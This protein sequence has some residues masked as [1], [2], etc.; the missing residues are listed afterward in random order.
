MLPDVGGDLGVWARR[1]NRCAQVPV[2]PGRSQ[3]FIYTIHDLSG[4]MT[5]LVCGGHLVFAGTHPTVQHKDGAM[6]LGAVIII[7]IGVEFRVAKVVQVVRN[8]G[9]AEQGAFA[10]RHGVLGGVQDDL[11]ALDNEIQEHRK[12]QRTDAEDYDAADDG[13]CG[14]GD[15]ADGQGDQGHDADQQCKQPRRV[16]DNQKGRGGAGDFH[17]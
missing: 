12:D 15:D 2:A 1:V 4:A 16:F 7:V 8:I 5:A 14:Q 3:P 6:G 17:A 13:S 10:D 9:V 11:H